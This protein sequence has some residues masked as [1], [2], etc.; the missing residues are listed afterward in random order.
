MIDALLGSVHVLSFSRRDARAAG[1]VRAN[2]RTRGRPSGPYDVLLA[3]CAV[4]RGLTLVTANI[5]EMS[6]VDG[7]AVQSWR[8]GAD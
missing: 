1:A 4:S 2:L 5:G 6:R 3:G 7:L 8:S